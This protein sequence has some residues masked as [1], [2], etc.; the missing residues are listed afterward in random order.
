MSQ[1]R[2][3]RD[4][5]KGLIPELPKGIYTDR[6]SEIEMVDEALTQEDREIEALISL[7]DNEEKSGDGHPHDMSDYGS[8]EED[9]DDL[10]LEALAKADKTSNALVS[11][12]NPSDQ[13]LDYEMDISID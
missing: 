8:D 5:E 1:A 11:S 6:T 12:R 3:G 13:N 9:F 2:P 10:F 4:G 7:L